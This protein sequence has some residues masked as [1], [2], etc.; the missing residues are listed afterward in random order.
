LFQ[1]LGTSAFPYVNRPL[2]RLIRTSYYSHK[3]NLTL[4]TGEKV[5]V[6]R[7]TLVNWIEKAFKEI[8]QAQKQSRKIA[9]TFRKCGLD[10]YDDV[11]AEFAKHLESLSEDSVYNALIQHQRAENITD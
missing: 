7:E 9:A 10:M 1:K 8:G 5:R 11:K 4:G 3:T 6:S 2:K